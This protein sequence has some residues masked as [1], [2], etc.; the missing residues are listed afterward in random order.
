MTPTRPRWTRSDMARLPAV[1]IITLNGQPHTVPQTIYVARQAAGLTQRGLA[2]KI[3]SSQ[4][5]LCDW[6]SE[7]HSPSAKSWIAAL[8]ACGYRVVVEKVEP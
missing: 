4:S 7:R 8:D 2:D 1:S 5:L 3:G 6:E